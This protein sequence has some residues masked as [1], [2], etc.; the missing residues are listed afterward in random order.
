[1]KDSEGYYAVEQWAMAEVLDILATMKKA[2]ED[3][4]IWAD[5]LLER[6]SYGMNVGGE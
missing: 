3:S 1:M 6:L 2:T 5:V 4:A